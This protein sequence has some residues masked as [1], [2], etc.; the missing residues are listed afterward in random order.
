MGWKY[1][2]AK[3]DR[4]EAQAIVYA[5]ANKFKTTWTVRRFKLPNGKNIYKYYIDTEGYQT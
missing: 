1:C 3:E 5:L 4:R 2:G